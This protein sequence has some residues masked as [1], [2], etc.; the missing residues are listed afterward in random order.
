M[1]DK[2][3]LSL[4]YSAWGTILMRVQLHIKNFQCIQ[5]AEQSDIQSVVGRRGKYEL[6]NVACHMCMVITPIVTVE[7]DEGPEIER[8]M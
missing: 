4:S 5:A 7:G 6:V 8:T 2:N 3:V 1:L